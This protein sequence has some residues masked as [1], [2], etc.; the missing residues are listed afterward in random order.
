MDGAR[1]VQQGLEAWCGVCEGP[2]KWCDGVLRSTVVYALDDGVFGGLRS[3]AVIAGCC[4]LVVISC[5]SVW[6]QKHRVVFVWAK[7]QEAKG[8]WIGAKQ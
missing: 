5:G 3:T 7:Q 8:S 1:A 4:G 6:L 2:G